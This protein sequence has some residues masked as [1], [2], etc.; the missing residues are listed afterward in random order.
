MATWPCSKR[1]RADD[2][3]STIDLSPCYRANWKS[4]HNQYY[5]IDT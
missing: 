3:A 1:T 2:L 5:G 4:H